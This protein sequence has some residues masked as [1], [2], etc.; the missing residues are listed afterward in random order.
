MGRHCHRDDDAEAR[1]AAA[2]EDDRKARIARAERR[3]RHA[4]AAAS[5]PPGRTAAPGPDTV[6]IPA[7][8]TASTA[9]HTAPVH[10]DA[11]PDSCRY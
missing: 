9:A 5:R 2:A 6:S 8:H 11:P 3:L 10:R 1:R 4:G 7:D